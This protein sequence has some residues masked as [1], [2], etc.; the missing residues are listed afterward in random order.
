MAAAIRTFGDDC[1]C[2]TPGHYCSVVFFFDNMEPLPDDLFT[3]VP[4][5]H[6]GMVFLSNPM[7]LYNQMCRDSLSDL[8]QGSVD[9]EHTLEIRYRQKELQELHPLYPCIGSWF[10]CL[11]RYARRS[12][13]NEICL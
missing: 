10:A 4:A 6:A 1:C 8:L 11:P 9:T 2:C 13:L 7:L 5:G 3:Y 12:F